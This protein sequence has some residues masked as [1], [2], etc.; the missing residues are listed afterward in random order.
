M[1]GSPMKIVE[2]LALYFPHA[3]TEQAILYLMLELENYP[4]L[5]KGVTVLVS[6]WDHQIS[7][8]SPHPTMHGAGLD[9]LLQKACPTSERLVSVICS[10][11]IVEV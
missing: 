4:V 5:L 11:Y 7:R 10:L 2:G 1:L 3:V 6:R 9:D 8:D